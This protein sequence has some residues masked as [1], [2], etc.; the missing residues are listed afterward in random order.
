MEED[1]RRGH[2]EWRGCYSFQDIICD[3][4]TG[5][6]SKRN[7]GLKMG[8]TYYYYVRNRKNLKTEFKT[9]KSISTKQT[10]VLRYMIRLSLLPPHANIYLGSP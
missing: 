6:L 4:D 5:N 9:D 10:T 2:G 3:G 1:I 8:Q 7:G